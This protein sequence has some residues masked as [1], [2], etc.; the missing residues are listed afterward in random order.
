[1]KEGPQ[2]TGATGSIE[3]IRIMFC[4]ENPKFRGMFRHCAADSH[5]VSASL[6]EMN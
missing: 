2:E 1:M 4:D 5:G 6:V 3:Y